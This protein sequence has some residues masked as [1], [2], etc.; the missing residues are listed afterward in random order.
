[1]KIVVRLI[2]RLQPP[3]AHT[4]VLW[5]KTVLIKPD[6][7][8]LWITLNQTDYFIQESVW[9]FNTGRWPEVARFAENFLF[10]TIGSIVFL[11]RL[12]GQFIPEMRQ[13]IS[14]VSDQMKDQLM[15]IN[16]ED[17]ADTFFMELSSII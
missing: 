15:D 4:R 1:M 8:E 17:V 5:L 14:N 10:R 2:H 16:I 12:T 11:E 6:I 13:E 9:K 3:P 7:G